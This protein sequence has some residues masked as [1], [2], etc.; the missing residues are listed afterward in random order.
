MTGPDTPELIQGSRESVMIDFQD[1]E[2]VNHCFQK[3]IPVFPTPTSTTYFLYI[4][5]M[6]KGKRGLDPD[7]SISYHVDPRE[8]Q[9]RSAHR[10]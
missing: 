1:Q 7:G 8:K 10:P 9:E 3:L 5:G 4:S 6:K 2:A